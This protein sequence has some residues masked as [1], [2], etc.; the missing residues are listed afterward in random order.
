MSSTFFFTKTANECSKKGLFSIKRRRTNLEEGCQ[1]T[2]GEIGS[3]ENSLGAQ[4]LSRRDL[5]LWV[6]WVDTPVSA[7]PGVSM[8]HHATQGHIRASPGAIEGLSPPLETPFWGSWGGVLARNCG[9]G[10][11]IEIWM[12]CRHFIFRSAKTKS[13][14]ITRL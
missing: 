10:E 7:S 2:F 1:T 3:L 4:L 12:L 11:V 5:T 6:V 9:C 13:A 14:V 8:R